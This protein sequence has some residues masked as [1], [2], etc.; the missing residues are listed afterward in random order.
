[1]KT[2]VA[3][4]LA[5]TPAPAHAPEVV[6]IA[7]TPAGFSAPAQ[8]RA[9]QLTLRVRSTDPAGAW[10]GIV[11][12]RVP[13]DRYLADV[14]RAFSNDP[15]E[16]VAGGKAVTADATM[17][18]G[19]AVAATPASVTVPVDCGR[20]VLIDFRDAS[21]LDL[22]TR[23]R[24]LDVLPRSDA[25]TTATTRI[26]LL[27]NRFVAPSSLVS[28]A[29][30]EV[31]NRSS[32]YNEAMLIP[33]AAGTTLRDL[34]DFFAVVN[35]GQGYPS[36]SPFTGGPTGVVPLSPGRAAVFSAALPAGRYALVTWIRDLR[37]GQ[38]Y[39]TQGMRTLVTLS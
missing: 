4:A 20:Y 1:M 9:G 39:A 30:V 14:R 26:T 33:V 21:L 37:T 5:L 16:E 3:I 23:V 35:A 19:V 29:P 12:L 17:L 25:P 36:T 27:E 11:R 18:G 7:V 8:V 34:D 6:D 15:V 38:M 31:V 13:L 10:L 22:A 2:L 32:Q 24:V 28:G